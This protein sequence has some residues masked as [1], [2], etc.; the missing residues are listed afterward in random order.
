MDDT[1][2]MD[3]AMVEANAPSAVRVRHR[4]LQGRLGLLQTTLLISIPVIGLLFVSNVHLSL[5]L[6]V[7][8]E[9]WVGLFLGMCLAGVFLTF[10]AV[11]GSADRRLPWY[12]AVLAVIATLPGLYLALAYP[13]IVRSFG[14]HDAVRA[15][16]S[17]IP[18]VVILEAI[19]RT[20]GWA[21]VS[22]VLVFLIYAKFGTGLPAIA[23]Q[24][25][26]WSRLLS[27]LYVDPGALMG[28]LRLAAT[29][30]LAFITFGQL[31]LHFGVGDSLTNI[32]LLLLGRFRGGTA[33]TAL[34]GSSL[35]GTITGAPMSNVFLTGTITIPMMIR[36]GYAPATAGGIEATV[37][38][39]GQIMPPV[40]GIAA[41]IVAENLGIPY[42]QVALA[43]LLP[44][45]L[46]YFG[47]Y[48]QVDLEAGKRNLLGVPRDQLPKL[49]TTLRE[50][51]V[52]LPI[53]GILVYTLFIIRM[54]PTNAAA[55]S[56]LA[57]VPFLL[58][59]VAHRRG[60]VRRILSTLETSG[61]LLLDVT[62]VLAAAGFVV[63]VASVSGL[64]FRIG[65]SC[66][67]Y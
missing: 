3:K 26:G 27:Y 53:L 43:A 19:R 62:A 58:L 23:A 67:L 63:G 36:S 42:S 13:S 28:M 56:T 55:V 6:L 33:K 64:G 45:I 11:K 29:I 8:T 7:F 61:R 44:A 24:P 2:V 17:A 14:S 4:V 1:D 15:T 37:S 46:F 12:D 47:V 38:T 22:V 65:Y 50:A 39:G 5:G 32:S 49:R 57:A 18:I 52:I 54:N 30:A 60:L 9:Q 25:T 66:L 51:W 40:M 48:V 21:L 16:F 59:Q 35:V 31:L 10:P 41:F 34:L 20:V